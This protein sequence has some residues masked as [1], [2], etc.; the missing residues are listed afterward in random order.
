MSTEQKVLRNHLPLCGGI[1]KLFGSHYITKSKMRILLT[2]FSGVQS[3][4]ETPLYGGK[5]IIEKFGG[6]YND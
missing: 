6:N 4:A 5:A 1:P 3:D 2:F